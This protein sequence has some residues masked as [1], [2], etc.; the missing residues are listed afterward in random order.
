[1]M[2][3]DSRSITLEHKVGLPVLR[4]I[5]GRATHASTADDPQKFGFGLEICE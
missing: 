5:T 3:G 2:G 1:M 4:L